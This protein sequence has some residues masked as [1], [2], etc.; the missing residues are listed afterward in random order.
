MER[1]AAA[2]LAQL[3]AGQPS[4]KLI[5]RDELAGL[6]AASS[7]SELAHTIDRR[8]KAAPDERPPS[9]LRGLL[10]IGALAGIARALFWL[11]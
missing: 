6:L 2:E 3:L 5:E 10:L 1:R 9:A 11:L 8:P 4:T 7:R